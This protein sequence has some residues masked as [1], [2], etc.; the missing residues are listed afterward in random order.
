MQQTAAEDA[1]AVGQQLFESV[2]GNPERVLVIAA[3]ALALV[4]FVVV[5][6][7]RFGRTPGDRFLDALAVSDG[8]AVLMHPNPDPDAMGSALAVAAMADAVG[9]PATIQYPGEIRHPENR[10][11]ETVLDCSFERLD[12]AAGLDGEDVVLVD[13]NEP[14]GFGGADF[15]EPYAVVDHHPGDGEGEAFTDVRPDRGSCASI[16]TEYLQQRGWSNDSEAS[17]QV[18]SP[19][20]A[21]G[22]LYGIQSDTTAFTR[23][24]THAEFEAAA[25]LFPAADG[26]SLD[27]IANPEVDG[28]TLDVKAK[29]IRDRRKDGS[30]LVSDVETLSNLDALPTA[31]EELVR[32]EGVS[33]SVVMGEANGAIHLSGRS[34]DDRVHM[35]KALERATGELSDASAGGHARMG[36]GRIE[37]PLSDGESG[38]AVDLESRLFA[39][40]KGEL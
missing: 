15:V 18:V 16:L 30:F 9:T 20:V 40:M 29:A 19:R 21:T 1:F 3:V 8:V 39:A 13:H 23:G 25:F 28:E 35:G 17:G 37:L 10:A 27:R 32:L 11:F 36:G 33:V 22:L 7:S 14:R 12:A 38:E 6:W 2:S 34:R 31:A 26:D 24:C 5:L 4:L